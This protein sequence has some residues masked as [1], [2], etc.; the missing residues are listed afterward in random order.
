MSEDP[1]FS[2]PADGIRFVVI[3][4]LTAIV[5]V[6]TSS[7]MVIL[8]STVNVPVMSALELAFNVVNE[9]AAAVPPIVTLSR[10][11]V[12]AGFT[13]KVE[14]DTL[15]AN[16][17]KDAL[18]GVFKP[19]SVLSIS[20][21]TPPATSIVVKAPVLGVVAPTVTPSILPPVAL[22]VDIVKPDRSKTLFDPSQ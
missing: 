2:V 17:V 1:K 11:P 12:V 20:L 8:P 7:P 6:A 14:P 22:I 5:S 18:L 15:T 4:A 21:P 9:P 10:L 16:P 3:A 13:V 19:I